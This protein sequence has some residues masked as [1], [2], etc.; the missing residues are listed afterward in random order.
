MKSGDAAAMLIPPPTMSAKGSAKVTLSPGQ[1]AGG[2][3]VIAILGAKTG[4]TPANAT[5]TMSKP[6]EIVFK[7]ANHYH[8]TRW[9][10]SSKSYNTIAR[11]D[12]DNAFTR[13]FFLVLV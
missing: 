7:P 10:Q 5:R 8:L 6:I 3:K 9:S 11:L 13:R 2:S 12:K 4:E 1:A